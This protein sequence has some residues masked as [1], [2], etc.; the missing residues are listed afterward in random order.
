MLEVECTYWNVS[1][2]DP[3]LVSKLVHCK[4]HQVGAHLY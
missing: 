4:T 3:L 1:F 2:R